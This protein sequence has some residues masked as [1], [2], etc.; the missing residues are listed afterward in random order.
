MFKVRKYNI[1]KK[2][3]NNDLSIKLHENNK[4]GIKVSHCQP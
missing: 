2:V 4:K 1:M 3:L